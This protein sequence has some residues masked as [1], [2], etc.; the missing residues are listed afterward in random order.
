MPRLVA[1]VPAAP[2]D[3]RRWAS[4]V[5]LLVARLRTLTYDEDGVARFASGRRE[6]LRLV[7]G[8]AGQVGATYRLVTRSEVLDPATQQPTYQLDDPV[9]ITVLADDARELR[10]RITTA[11]YVADGTIE[12]PGLPT[13]A[14][15][16]LTLTPP[17]LPAWVGERI[18]AT[19]RLDLSDPS[20][21]R[22]QAQGQ[23]KAADGTAVLEHT[24]GRLRTELAVKPRGRLAVAVLAWPFVRG[25]ARRAVTE[26]LAEW[27]QQVQ[28]TLPSDRSLEE[29]ADEAVRDL[30]ESV[31]EV[32]PAGV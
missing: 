32:V 24:D 7:D 4:L 16:T 8:V 28:A 19:G 27:W 12:I 9:T 29:V 1:E 25:K 26:G 23:S 17:D 10:A 11:E 6:G 14:H 2:V 20:H 18:E 3:L 21:P 5:P 31:V 30:E 13:S 15:L 22:V